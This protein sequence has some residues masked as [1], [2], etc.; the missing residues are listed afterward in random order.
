M[1]NQ[2]DNVNH[3]INQ[4]IEHDNWYEIEKKSS[5]KNKTEGSCCR[6]TVGLMSMI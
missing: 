1:S 4:S 6:L 3:S 2:H 5:E